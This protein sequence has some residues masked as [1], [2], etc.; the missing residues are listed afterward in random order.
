MG[1]K[2]VNA[3]FQESLLRN[4]VKSV[5]YLNNPAWMLRWISSSSTFSTN[6]EKAISYFPFYYQGS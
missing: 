6:A 3:A 2:A 5:S 1:A 4:I